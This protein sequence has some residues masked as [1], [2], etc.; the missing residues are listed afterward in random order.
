MIKAVLFD[1]GGVL[2]KRLI[3]QF[4]VKRLAKDLRQN[5]I[6]VG[7]L[8]NI[9]RVGSLYLRLAG[10]YRGFDPVILSFKE[11]IS[12]PEVKI[13][14]TAI[15]RLAVRPQE[16]IFVDNLK[17]NV[18]VAKQLGMKVVLAKNSSQVI[19]DIK[20]IIRQENKLTL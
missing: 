20:K 3:P 6:K 4:T 9:I 14:K 10:G 5:G 1:Y 11:K 18:A 17:T 15:E 13:Y 7:I 8:S 12:K 2:S 19:K 16:I